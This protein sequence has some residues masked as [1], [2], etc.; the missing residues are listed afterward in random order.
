MSCSSGSGLNLHR[1]QRDC[2]GLISSW[3][4]VEGGELNSSCNILVQFNFLSH[5]AE[6]L[7]T[8]TPVVF[9]FLGG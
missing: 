8:I 5:Y 3:P 1:E 9:L 2:N 6:S 4:K 7:K